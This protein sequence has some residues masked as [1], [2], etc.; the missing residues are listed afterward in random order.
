MKWLADE[1]FRNA[2]LQG[3]LRRRPTLAVLRSQEMPEICGV[4]DRRLLEF[5][6]DAGR[7]VLTHDFAMVAS[8]MEEPT[9]R[10]PK[11][12]PIV[13]IPDSLPVSA[14]VDDVLLLD[15]CANGSD[16]QSGVLCL[17]LR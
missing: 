11:C 14:V 13:L 6:T 8:A 15:E 7:I 9:R 1:N 5:A 10:R 16:W 3:L 17:P 12:A 2:I 4:S